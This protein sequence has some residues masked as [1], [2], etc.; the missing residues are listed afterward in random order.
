MS[1]GSGSLSPRLRGERAGVRGVFALALLMIASCGPDSSHPASELPSTAP[2]LTAQ[3]D[4]SDLLAELEELRRNG[5]SHE[6]LSRVRQALE[7]S[8]DA[9]LLHFNL[10]LFL[11]STG[12]FAT[13]ETAVNRALELQPAHFPSHR[14]LGDLARQRGAPAEAMEHY[15]RCVSGL[16][17]H[18]GC[19][20]GLGLAL[21]DLGELDAAAGHLGPAAEQLERAGVWSELG[22]LERRRR[23]LPESIAA[24][25]HALAIDRAHLPALLGMGQVL[26]A[27]GRRD[28]GEALLEKH[29]EEAARQDQINALRRAANQPGAAVDILLQLA[30]LY[31]SRDDSGAAE[32]A[33]RQALDRSPPGDEMRLP[34]ILALANHRLHQGDAAEADELVERLMPR[35]SGDPAVLFLQGTIDLARGD[36]AA[37]TVHFDASLAIGSWPPP[38]YLDAGKAWSAAGFPEQAAGAFER[39]AAGMPDSAEAH[40]GLAKSRRALGAVD[41]SLVSLE[42]ALEVAPAAGR[43][44]LL[45][46]V[47]RAE[48]GDREEARRAFA[49]GLEVRQLDLLPAN[50]AAEIRRELEA[51]APP[52]TALELFDEALAKSSRGARHERAD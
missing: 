2:G 23:R 9:A 3:K 11:Q 49:R 44:W 6:G 48:R 21:V 19:R 38:V 37:A 33:L 8:P 22:Q 14:V 45:L 34:A 31:R 17:D 41:L 46:G 15:G 26:V 36:A 28:E 10:G 27:A 25:S 4:H 42:R 40:L 52:A 35:M 18:A 30:Q 24:Y 20:Y 51:L 29:R 12:D 16:P 7:L 32:A 47:L 13:A 50:G 5:S 39:A 1:A 43:A